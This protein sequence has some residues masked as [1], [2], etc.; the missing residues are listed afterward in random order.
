MLD[1]ITPFHIGE[2]FTSSLSLL[3]VYLVSRKPRFFD[4][5]KY[6]HARSESA[7]GT[8]HFELNFMNSEKRSL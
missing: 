7:S 5:H 3:V 2:L 6:K 1:K 4:F 8:S